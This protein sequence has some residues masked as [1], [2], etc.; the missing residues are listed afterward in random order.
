M[1]GLTGSS[2]LVIGRSLGHRNASTT[3]IYARLTEDPVR[4]SAQRAYRAMREA[5]DDLPECEVLEFPKES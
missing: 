5:A 4:A 3:Q 1:A 2:L